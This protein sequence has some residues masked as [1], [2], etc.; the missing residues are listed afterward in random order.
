MSVQNATY[1]Q[2]NGKV[3]L[4]IPVA[5]KLPESLIAEIS[6]ALH[7]V[8]GFGSIEMYVQDHSVTQITV[9]A[10]KKTKH[11]IAE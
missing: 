8:G 5:I 7:S 2:A 9:R 11:Y 4:H 10:I 6:K 1:P 3:T